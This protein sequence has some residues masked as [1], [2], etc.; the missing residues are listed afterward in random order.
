[1]DNIKKGYINRFINFNFKAFKPFLHFFYTLFWF[2]SLEC[3][4]ILANNTSYLNID[5]ELLLEISSV[6]IMLFFF[7][8]VDEI[9][10][11]EYDMKYN[12]S[13]PLVTGEVT[14]K[15]LYIYII[16]SII[17]LTVINFYLSKVLLL[18]ISID[19]I[20]S[21]LLVFI[22]KRSDKIK[23]N[24]FINMAF[25]YPINILLNV[26]ICFSFFTNHHVSP[27]IASIGPLCAFV[28]VYL[29]FEFSRKTFW[30]HQ[31][32]GVEQRCYSEIIGVSGA[33]L[34]IISCGIIPVL[35][36]LFLLEPWRGDSIKDLINWSILIPYIPLSWGIRKFVKTK[37]SG[38]KPLKLGVMTNYSSN[39]MT[40]YFL[41]IIIISL[42]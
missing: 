9:K 3:L 36:E 5:L 7:R 20:Y 30:P 10:D 4:L 33:L 18:I 8:V 19:I 13:R 17:I 15:E 23:N 29:T 42:L 38:S 41:I 34:L 28:I 26:Y 25:S 6:F 37:N 27:S 11:Y 32:S 24:L 22:E 16:S 39:Y 31:I 21:L 12:K 14:R 2:L 1:M 40:L 35:I